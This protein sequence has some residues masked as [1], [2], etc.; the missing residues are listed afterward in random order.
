MAATSV[1]RWRAGRQQSAGLRGCPIRRGPD[2]IIY[3]RYTFTG[4]TVTANNINL[5]GDWIIGDGIANRISNPGFFSLSHTLTISN[6]VEQLGGFI[7]ASN[8]TIDDQPGSSSRL[9]LRTPAAKHGRAA[10]RW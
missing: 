4:G 2:G 3:G 5:T 10:S 1:R 7:L 8:A 6:A 9:S